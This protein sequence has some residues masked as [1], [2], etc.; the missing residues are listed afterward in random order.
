METES[1][2]K[3]FAKLGKLMQTYADKMAFSPSDFDNADLAELDLVVNNAAAANRWFTRENIIYAIK[4]I[5]MNLDDKII[6]QWVD[7][8]PDSYFYPATIKNIGVVMAGNIPMVGFFDFFYVLMSGN[9][10]IAKLSSDDYLLLPFFASVLIKNEPAI[11]E[12]IEFTRSQLKNA[13][14]YIATGSD[15]SARYFD[16]YF[17]KYPNIIRRNRCSAAVLTGNESDDELTLLAS[18]IF[19]YFGLGCRNVSKIFIPKNYDLQRLLK[20]FEAFEMLKN[21]HTYFCNY[22]YNKAIYLINNTPHFDNGFLLLK[23][24]ASLFSP[25]AVL[26][27]EYYNDPDEL[28]LKIQSMSDKI[29]CLVS[30]NADIKHAVRIGSTQQPGLPDYADGVDVLKFIATIPD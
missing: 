5:S 6:R 15:N 28:N 8:Y 13:D 18:D 30:Q 12:Y 4:A 11:A 25:V 7:S 10:I 19:L 1:R 3:A 27:Y 2:I 29:Q 16:Y 21:H 22:E 20:S 24:D 17:G 26:Y 23:E 9:R 14:A